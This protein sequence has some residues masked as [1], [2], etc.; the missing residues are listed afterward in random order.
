MES[1]EIVESMKSKHFYLEND[2]IVIKKRVKGLTIKPPLYLWNLT[3]SC[4][5]SSLEYNVQGNNFL[6]DILKNGKRIYF[7]LDIKKNGQ[8]EVK[9]LELS[10]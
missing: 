9:K 3:K 7:S 2:D 10:A 4:Y 1:T 8:L 6:F 5:V